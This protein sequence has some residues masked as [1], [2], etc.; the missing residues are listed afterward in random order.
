MIKRLFLIALFCLPVSAEAQII[1]GRR[2][3]TYRLA[4]YTALRAQTCSE[5]ERALLTASIYGGSFVCT[6]TPD[7]STD[8]GGI[9]I[10]E[11]NDAANEWWEREFDNNSTE[12]IE[13]DWFDSGTESTTAPYVID[14][15]TDITNLMTALKGW[16]TSSLYVRMPS[17]GSS[18]T[19]LTMGLVTFSNNSIV[20]IM[21]SDKAVTIDHTGTYDIADRTDYVMFD[22]VDPVELVMGGV[23]LNL[24]L[25]GN[26]AD[27]ASPVG[28]NAANGSWGLINVRRAYV[29]GTSVDVRLNATNA[30]S[31]A[32]YH[33]NGID[34]NCSGGTAY[35]TS[36]VN[37]AGTYWGLSVTAGA[38]NVWLD[39][40]TTVI[41][42][43]YGHGAGWT[44]TGGNVDYANRGVKS[45]G[46]WIQK[47]NV[48]GGWTQRYGWNNFF[49]SALT[50]AGTS[51]NPVY[52]RWD[53]LGW[54]ESGTQLNLATGIEQNAGK[55]DAICV[56]YACQQGDYY[57][58]IERESD[59]A[60]AWAVETPVF[61]SAGRNV[62][63]ECQG[64][65]V[66][67]NAYITTLL[68]NMPA[69]ND[70]NKGIN[71]KSE[72]N[73]QQT[74]VTDSGITPP[75]SNFAYVWEGVS[76][77]ANL[78][79]VYLSRFDTLRSGTFDDVG[80]CNRGN[81]GPCRFT[82]NGYSSQ[83]PVQYGANNVIEDVTL[84]GSISVD[85]GVTGTVLESVTMSSGESITFASGSFSCGAQSTL[86][87]DDDSN[88]D[89]VWSLSD[90]TDRTTLG[91][92]GGGPYTICAP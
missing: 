62:G 4:D 17:T 11:G 45:R 53:S 70:T 15:D 26:F 84:T 14:T 89:G 22:F 40:T 88:S 52:V 8:D 69:V 92:T 24:T 29:N 19:S 21:E 71:M 12:P 90:A 56:G 48:E 36:Q 30:M 42:D 68:G 20:H 34:S 86:A 9:V 16:Y 32:F 76:G 87:W 10:D 66:Y 82:S 80:V 33:C 1:M 63:G 85:S 44:G 27:G 73:C 50:G 57:F 25:T 46:I 81:S 5:G 39:S 35:T 43:P 28:A 47:T 38:D 51:A 2:R 37:L 58:R 79:K 91:A 49:V 31:R 64:S 72:S 61:W 6:S 41:A 59:D 77:K 18:I 75:D 60:S 23:N 54:L 67:S 3:T 13:L 65:T 7:H 83:S 74:G 78:G 55:S